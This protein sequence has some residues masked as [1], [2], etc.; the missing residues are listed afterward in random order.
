MRRA[1]W[2][3]VAFGL[4][5]LAAAPTLASDFDHHGHHGYYDHH[6]YHG[7]YGG[8][9]GYGTVVVRPPVVVV[10]PPVVVPVYPPAVVYPPAYGVGRYYCPQ[11][12]GYFQYRGP[13]VSIGI[14][15]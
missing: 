7:G 3:L 8:Y 2:I 13:R 1:T 4:L 9:G 10:R 12:D 14:G 15:L 6:G 11:P 5:A